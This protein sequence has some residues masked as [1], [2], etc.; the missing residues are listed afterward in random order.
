M[1]EP[2]RVGE[3]LHEFLKSLGP[4]GKAV[5]FDERWHKA[6][7]PQLGAHSAVDR[8]ADG[9]L[10]IAVSNGAWA[11]EVRFTEAELL[12]SLN[13]NHDHGPRVLRIS[14][15]VAPQRFSGKAN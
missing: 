8:F 3:H 14:I 1:T 12:A 9:Q 15:R 7:G 10:Q 2:R 11:T 5:T 13:R 4:R 6:A